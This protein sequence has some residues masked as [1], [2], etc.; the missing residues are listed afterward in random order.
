MRRRPERRRPVHAAE[1]R[2]HASMTTTPDGYETRRTRPSPSLTRMSIF[3][4][5]EFDYP[6]RVGNY[7]GAG[8]INVSVTDQDGFA[9]IG[10]CVTIQGPNSGEVCDN[11]DGDANSEDGLI[12][13]ENLPDGD[14]TVS[15]SQLAAGLRACRAGHRHDQWRPGRRCGLVSGVPQTESRPRP[16]RRR[17]AAC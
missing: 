16:K 10:A 17:Q 7:G 2:V 13:I 9:I 8:A 11:G 4:Y 14:Y 5:C 6:D 12:R 15:V 3:R 1:R